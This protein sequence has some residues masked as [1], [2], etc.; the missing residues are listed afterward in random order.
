M[1]TYISD[2]WQL[3]AN[4]GVKYNQTEI[5]G[6]SLDSLTHL[7]GA[8]TRFDLT[9]K[10]DLSLRGQVLANED[11]SEAQYSFG[12]SIGISPIKDVWISLGYNFEGFRDD[13]FEAAEFSRDGIF[14]RFRGKFDQDTAQG[15]LRRISPSSYQTR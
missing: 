11:F 3:S 1:N 5:N 14:L 4:Y 13:D 12:P 9:K 15:L 2:R 10:I 8:E 7:L 6:Q